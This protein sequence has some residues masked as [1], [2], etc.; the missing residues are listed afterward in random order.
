MV[1]N[2]PKGARHPGRVHDGER[3][4]LVWLLHLSP[5]ARTAQGEF[6]GFH[7]V[8]LLPAASGS[9]EAY[10]VGDALAADGGGVFRFGEQGFAGFSGLSAINR[11]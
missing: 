8:D 11:V 9:E 5:T 3:Q 4:F 1:R 6:G 2:F 10:A 7:Q